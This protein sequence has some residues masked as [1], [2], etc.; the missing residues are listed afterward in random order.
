MANISREFQSMVL[1]T[2]RNSRNTFASVKKA[3]C[4]S[5]QIIK[6]TKNIETPP[7]PSRSPPAPYKERK[8][9]NID[10]DMGPYEMM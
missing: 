4:P 3:D 6:Q 10:T 7:F 1:D 9:E 8:K 2:D 5:K